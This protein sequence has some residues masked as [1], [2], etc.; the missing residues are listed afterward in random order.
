MDSSVRDIHLTHP[1]C[2]NFSLIPNATHTGIGGVLLTSESIELPTADK[3]MV[4]SMFI[5]EAETL[6][7]VKEMVE[8]DV[9]Y[10]SGVVSHTFLPSG[11][12]LNSVSN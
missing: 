10:T 4:G 6:A 2:E 9:Y 7:K 1:F 12:S 8:G 11:V 5:C 3:Q